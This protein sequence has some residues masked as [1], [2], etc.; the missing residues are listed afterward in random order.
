MHRQIAGKLTGPVTKWIVLAAWIVAPRGRRQSLPPSSPT[1]RTTRRRPG[2][3]RRAESTQVSE[4]LSDTVDPNNIPTLIVYSRDGGLTDD[5]LAAI[6]EQAAEIAEID[7]VVDGHRAHARS[8]P[9]EAGLRRHLRGRRG[10]GHVADLQLRHERLER[11]PRRRRRDPRDHRRSTASPC[12]SPGYGGQAADAAEAFEGIDT[13]PDPDHAARGDRDPAVHLPQPAAVDAADLQRRRRLHRLRRRGLPA[14]QVR[15]PD[16]QRPEPGDPRH[17]GDRRRHRLRPAARR[18]LPRGAASPRGPARGDGVRAAP[19]RP[20]DP[21]QRRHRRRRHALPD[22][23]PTSTP[24]PASARS[25]PS[26][27]PSPSS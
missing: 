10:R 22:R 19:R 26:A 27:S 5:D 11:H 15:R 6:E 8:R 21:R 23:S 12:T 2:C 1:S 16:G 14:G 9:A 18:P 13:Q 7:G 24:P 3:P 4:E 25:S 17:P 20:G